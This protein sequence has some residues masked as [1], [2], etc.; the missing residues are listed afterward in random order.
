MAVLAWQA[1]NAGG[2]FIAGTVIQ[3][4]ASF[5]N[6]SYQAT[7]WQ[8]TLIVFATV[9]LIWVINVFLIQ[10]LSTIQN[11]LMWVYVS[12]FIAITA[13]LWAKAPLNTAAE[14]FTVFADGGGWESVGLSLM[15]GQITAIYGIVGES[16]TPVQSG[17]L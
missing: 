1:G 9:L 8:G 15:I 5:N 3:A 14:V 17:E 12:A 16:M 11:V 10:W 13:V 2:A 6:S 4:I 7:S